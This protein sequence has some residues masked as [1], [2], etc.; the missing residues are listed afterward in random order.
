VT[1]TDFAALGSNQRPT[2]IRLSSG[3]LFF[4]SDYQHRRGRKPDTIKESGSFVALSEDEGKTWHLRTIPG[5]LPHEDSVDPDS[6]ATIGYAVARQAPNGVIH[7]VTSMNHPSLHFEMNEAWI[8][9]K[10]D[11]ADSVDK[12]VVFEEREEYPDGKLKALWRGR[13][14]RDGR[15]L[16]DGTETWYYPNGHKQWEVTYREGIK[17]GP[18]TYWGPDGQARW[19]WE[20]QTDG[21]SKWVQWWPNG[22]KRSESTWRDG[23]CV[24]VAS[25]WDRQGKLLIKKDFSE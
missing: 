2:L 19:E 10:E 9:N 14:G 18:E 8:L 11:A 13:L 3:R 23:R 15:Y 5:A 20:H 7:L 6:P 1:R 21:K 4:A 22:Q 16:L 17:V 24:G 12:G 25:V